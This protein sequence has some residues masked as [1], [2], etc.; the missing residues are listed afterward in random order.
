[1]MIERDG[2]FYIH[3]SVT[4]MILRIMTGQI[5]CFV[6]KI[7]ES[8]IEKHILNIVSLVI[9]GSKRR[10]GKKR[11]W[12]E[13]ER[14]EERERDKR[15][16]LKYFDRRWIRTQATSLAILPNGSLSTYHNLKDKA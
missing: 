8:G 6:Q 3:R 13:E 11:S 14:R 7:P 1:M 5:K 4:D 16:N 2:T 12:R 15:I 10:K 9:W